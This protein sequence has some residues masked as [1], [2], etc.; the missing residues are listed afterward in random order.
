M[1][2]G[3]VA[4]APLPS[5]ASPAPDEDLQAA[6]FDA[7]MGRL[8]AQYPQSPEALNARLEYADFLLAS[9][10]DNC[11]RPAAAQ[12]QLD[13]L[14]A[15][16]ALVILLPLS[17]ARVADDEYKIHAARA[18]CGNDPSTRKKELEQALAAAEQAMSL[19]SEG[20]DY[21][22]AAIMQ[23]NVAV[24]RHEL[25]D[26]DQ[27]LAALEAAIAMDRDYGLR[28]DAEDNT[29]LLLRWKQQPSAAADVAA[30]M[31]DF[32]ARTL[33]FKFDWSSRDADVTIAADDFSLVD[34]KPIKSHGAI[35][36][37]RRIR[38]GASGWTVAN[39]PGTA[40]YQL[41][42]WPAHAKGSEWSM[43][44]FLASAL[45]Q[46]P[47]IEIARN[48]DFDA[49]NDGEDFSNKL[50]V[51]VSTRVDQLLPESD[52]AAVEVTARDVKTA[53]SP[54]FIESSAEQ[55]YGIETGTWIGAKLEQGVWYQMTTP[56]FLPALGLGHYI[57]NQDITF[58][59][60][61]ELP[62][63]AEA[64]AHL[65]AE[66]VL[67]A[68]PAAD[69]FKDAI[70]A[71]NAQLKLPPSQSVHYRARTD[72]RLVVDPGT[73]FPYVRDIRQSWFNRLDEVGGGKSPPPG[74]EQVRVVSTVS[75]H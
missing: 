61:R 74:I 38:A 11:Q 52:P 57:A 46:A 3:A 29:G 56:L 27:A 5:P 7:A 50:A 67:H 6:D 31:K 58:A 10:G 30:A 37:E 60:T 8:S 73:L 45:M 33:A 47:T 64:P 26:S 41:G 36:L 55:D 71:V 70:K 9:A 12:A 53:Y 28:S 18:D 19:Y 35:S 2:L 23:Y 22:S 15:E 16:P 72:I 14:T 59:F 39:D 32:P 54:D 49:V 21:Q 44:F 48:G 63:T 75:Y 25:G 24:T 4:C 51:E 34:G 69:D 40:H 65:C 20:L 66:I 43:I 13:S 62:C 1:M 68:T 42:D 17:S